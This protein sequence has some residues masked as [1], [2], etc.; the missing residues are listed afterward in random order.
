MTDTDEEIAAE[1]TYRAEARAF[2]ERHAKLRQ[3]FGDQ[4][5]ALAS[6]D[7][8][9]EAEDEHIRRCRE[10]QRTL[11]ENGWAG[12]TWPTEY[13]GQGGTGRE[14]RIYAQ[15]EVRF[16]VSAAAFAI[17]TQMV[18]PTIMAHGTDEQKAF[19]LPKMLS[20]DHLWCQLFS[21][22][23]A[24]SDLAGM[25][26]T[27][28][29]DGDEFVVNG[30]KVWTS[31]AHFSDYAMLLARTN[32]DVPKHRGI[33]YFLV[34]M[35]SAG[36]DVRPLRQIT[37]FA[38]FNE[39]FLTDVRI[40]ADAVLGGLNNGWMVAQTTLANER[41][42]IG[43]GGTGINFN[44]IL[45]LARECGVTD[46]PDFRQQ[47]ASCYTRF[48]ILKW[49]GLRARARAAA[50]QKLGPEAS[51]MKLFVSQRI[52]RDGDLVLAMEGAHGMLRNEDAMQDGMWQQVFL[53]QWSIRIGGGTEQIQRN[54]LGERVLGL[55]GDIRVDKE[56]PFR[57]I[58]RN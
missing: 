43:S 21:E 10:W 39:V 36:I 7:T 19:F 3:G 14:A 38:H 41:N 13:G 45:R 55:P 53:N 27:A 24:G 31:G 42:M 17:G 46:D 49:I 29:R 58:R 4:T 28:V 26:T 40:P 33:T 1:A 52:A 51:V 48:E 18:G 47:L 16:D 44:A 9:K 57:E 56:L 20:G 23:G 15:E 37:G 34:D 50:G 22:P 11:F 2:L 5:I 12:I 25:T 35:R 54:V 8:S 30:Q 32:W 6:T